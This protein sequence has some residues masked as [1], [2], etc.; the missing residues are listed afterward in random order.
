MHPAWIEPNKEG[1]LV[2]VCPIDEIHRSCKEFLVD[3]FHALLGERPGVFALLLAPG[4]ETG[5]VAR[6]VGGDRDALHDT[7]RTELRAERGILRI[8]RI[9]RL[10]L[11]VEV[12]EVAE[13]FIEAVDGRQELV[14]VAKMV[15]AELS[16]RIS[17]RF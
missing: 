10:L 2:T 13:E 4:T 11:G 14:A 17:L 15:L 8:V 9:L 1:F 3:C 16:G 12:I 6:R 5:V 7:A